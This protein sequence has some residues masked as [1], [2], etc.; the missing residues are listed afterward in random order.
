[1][2]NSSLPSLKKSSIAFVAW[3]FHFAKREFETLFVHRFSSETMPLTNLWKNCTYYWAF[4]LVNGYLI[5]RPH[6]GENNSIFF[7][8]LATIIFAVSVFVQIFSERY[9]IQFIINIEY[10]KLAEIGNGVTHLQLRNLRPAGTKKR[11]I[12]RGGFF[13]LVSCPN[14]TCEILSWIAFSLLTGSLG[15]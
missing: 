6:F 1:M 3:I 12:P 15:R 14:Y 7:A 13:N 11:G 9:S 4:A 10:S 2:I 5:N 8:L